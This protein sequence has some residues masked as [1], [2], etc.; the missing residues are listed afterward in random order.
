MKIKIR[1]RI[2]SKSKSKII[3]D[4]SLLSVARLRFGHSPFGRRS[5]NHR[6]H[7]MTRKRESCSPANR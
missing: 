7:G 3:V 1:K 5:L 2:K 4:S 6:R